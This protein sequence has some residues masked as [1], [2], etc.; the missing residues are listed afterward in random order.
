MF[1]MHQITGDPIYCEWGWEV[2]QSIEKYC[3]TK[4]ACGSLTNVRKTDQVLQD[5][6]E[7][8]FLAET[9]KYLYLLQE[10]DTPV[11]VLHKHVFYT[12]AH[13]MRILPVFD[14][15]G[16]KIMESQK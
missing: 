2:F 4:V 7:S 6:M 14:D 1:I 15:T 11:D 13:P 10:P 16:G 3:K 9:L 8:L 12:E 5:K